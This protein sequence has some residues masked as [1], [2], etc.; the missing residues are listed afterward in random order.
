M[1]R[2]K[3]VPLPHACRSRIR[4]ALFLS[5]IGIVLT[6]LGIWLFSDSVKE[7]ANLAVLFFYSFPSEFLVGLLPHEPM[8]LYFG[9]LRDPL[10]VAL[11]AVLGTVITEALNYSVFGFVADSKPFLKYL[12]HRSVRGTVRLFRKSPFLA[13]WMAAVTPIPFYPFRF[14]AV[15]GRYPLERYLLAVFLG[16][17]P[18]FYL[19]AAIGDMFKFPGP[20]LIALFLILVAAFALPVIRNT[21]RAPE[22]EAE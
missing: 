10:T 22:T 6:F 12:Q 8:L 14:L 4:T 3:T 16:R 2:E 20:V 15:L 7:S 11:V 13:V 1:T 19:L 9:A 21:V 17:A 18:R 5:E